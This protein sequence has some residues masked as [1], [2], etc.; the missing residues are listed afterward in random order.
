VRARKRAA[1]V[2]E[3]RRTPFAAELSALLAA[4]AVAGGCGNAP[5]VIRSRLFIDE[6]ASGA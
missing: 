5:P 1:G 3:P 6:A 4:C 2:S